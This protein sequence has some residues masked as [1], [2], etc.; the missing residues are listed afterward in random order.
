VVVVMV[1]ALRHRRRLDDGEG[2]RDG[3]AARRDALFRSGWMLF[4]CGSLPWWVLSSSSY[5]SL[6]T[7]ISSSYLVLKCNKK[8]PDLASSRS[9]QS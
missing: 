1:A 9:Y 8:Y 2:E 6:I 3:G 5:T 4:M 7:L